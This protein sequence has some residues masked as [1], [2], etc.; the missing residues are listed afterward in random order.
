MSRVHAVYKPGDYPGTPDEET[1]KDLS[2]LFDYLFPGSANP[3]LD[4]GHAG[5]AIAALNP[6]LALHLA[7]L[8][9]FIALE[10]SWR[11]R[12][13][14]LELAVQTAHL[15]FNCDF[16]FEARLPQAQASG[17]GVER[18]AAIPYWRTTTLFDEEQ[19][20]V[21][22]YTNAVVCGDVPDELFSR[23][24]ARFGEKGAVEL[25]TAVAWWSFW[26]M[27]INAARPELDS[28]P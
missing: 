8:S 20:L 26:A 2:E 12:R 27:I 15:H 4:K 5:I 25:T 16:S 14:L 28:G 11:E 22:E 1:R 18:L 13:D 17:L 7:K 19:R 6:K 21:V 24:V 23:V 3:E 10:T 9:R